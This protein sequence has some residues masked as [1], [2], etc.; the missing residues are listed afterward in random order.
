VLNMDAALRRFVWE[1]SAAACE[2]CRMPDEFDPLPFC[3]DHVIAKQHHGPTAEGNLA[4]ACFN[5]N[6]Y[7]GPNIGGL[8]PD[9]GALTR[10]FHP[11]TDAWDEHFAWHGPRLHGRTPIGRTTIDVLQINAPE[12]VE[13]RR[14][15][16][17]EGV[18][19]GA[20]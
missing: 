8:D 4:L 7:K 16:I 14:L 3:V 1:R 9:T 19:P 20:N 18:F 5:C 12:R 11:R 17:E 13:H 2:Y 10:L 6:S 15:L